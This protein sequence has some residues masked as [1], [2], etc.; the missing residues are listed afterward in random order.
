MMQL[1]DKYNR[2]DFITFLANSFLPEFKRD[3][4]SVGQNGLSAIEKAY[5]L[6]KSDKLGLQVFEFQYSGS[7]KKRVTLTKEAFK[8]MQDHA[9][10]QALGVFFGK[11]GSD[12]RFSL[13]LLNPKVTEKGKVKIAHSN[14]RRYSYFLG[15][16]AKINTPHRFLIKNGQVNDIDDLQ[17]RFNV[18]IVTKEFFENYKKLYD[19]LVTYLNKDNAFQAFA[20]RNGINTSNF[21]K[22]LL[23]QIV[24]IYFLQR[25]GW[26]G[27]KKGDAIS[28]GDKNFVRTLFNKSRDDKQNFFNTY[29][30]P[31]FYSALNK[32]AEKAGSYFRSYFNCQIPFL[33]GGL[34]EPPQ[35]YD[36]E[37]SFLHLPDKIF[38]KDQK[39]PEHGDGILD[40]FDLYNFTVDE[41]DAF[42]KEVSV[43]PE[44]LGKVFEN[45]LE[46]NLRK[47]KGTYYTPREIVHYM[48]QESLIN[49][50]QNEV[51]STNKSNIEDLV[52]W[53]EL[54]ID[55][56]SD[57]REKIVI[58]SPANTDELDTALQSIK[59]VDPACGSGAFLVGMLQEIVKARIH[60]SYIQ[61]RKISEY[62]LKKEAIQKSIYG[63]DIDPGAVEIAKLR[64]WLSLVVDYELDVIE[65]LPNLD[66]RIMQ[67]NSLLE[68]LVLGDTAVK[69]YD[70]STI[71][72]VA[73]SKKMKNLFEKETMVG[74][75]DDGKEQVLKDMK[76]LQLEYFTASD[77]K[78]KKRLRDQIE[79]IEHKLIEETI[80]STAQELKNQKLNIRA[81]PGIGILPHDLKKLEKISSLENQIFAVLDELKRTGTKPFFLWHLYFADVFEEKGGFDVVIANPPYF[82]SRDLPEFIKKSYSKLYEFTKSGFDLATLFIELADRLIKP[83][84][85]ISFILTN[86]IFSARYAQSLRQFLINS[87]RLNQIINL[88]PRL[89][90]STPVETSVMIITHDNDKL[91]YNNYLK[92]D[93]RANFNIQLP[94]FLDPILFKKLPNDIFIFPSSIVDKLLF[95]KLMAL[96]T[97]LS[98][99]YI[100][101]AGYGITGI[102][103]SLVKERSGSHQY[104]VYTGKCIWRYENIEPEYFT[105]DIANKKTID[106]SFAL[107]RELSTK[108]RATI[109]ENLNNG[110]ALNSI[111][112]ATA[113]LDSLPIEIFIG[114]FNS[115]LFYKI[116][117]LFYESTRTHS[118]LRFKSIYLNDIPFPDLNKADHTLINQIK[119]NVD[120]ILSLENNID[121]EVKQEII[122]KNEHLIYELY[123]L[124]SNEVDVIEENNK[125][126]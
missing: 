82:R 3:I 29:L 5:S 70:Q 57:Q 53:G 10:Y 110:L 32:P 90:E 89:F 61:G 60:L 87:R 9:S 28:Q 11:E 55:E 47:G 62:D 105:N 49:Y 63:V 95:D 7:S 15:P 72:K 86:K 97:K 101:T 113:R 35:N 114:V 66:Y 83:H 14:P 51:K 120:D 22:K 119:K 36:W 58:L 41:G 123:G 121:Q 34:F 50:L 84:G 80:Q 102:K 19:R 104:P 1:D 26:L 38:S 85:T 56:N 65:P 73:N 27:A 33:N 93:T 48:C 20:S 18:E 75:F 44:M 52:K 100:F 108:N 126:K 98:D 25:K 79:N 78:E 106:S 67:G 69:L 13:M 107:I 99:F 109:I 71:R 39:N 4:R 125:I 103:S 115:N 37:H 94:F 16:N 111:T 30:E 24:F 59:I 77:G 23:G 96:S 8:I 31:L 17:S 12:W 117:C 124:G 112:L 6:G 42:D 68:E 45:L 118:N 88:Y 40:T 116:Y 43:D 92:R 76:R 54:N 122:E 91:R 74:L 2:D 46:E 21:A 81:L 64:L